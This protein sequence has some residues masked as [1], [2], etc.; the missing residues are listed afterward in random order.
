MSVIGAA[1]AADIMETVGFVETKAGPGDKE[2]AYTITRSRLIRILGLLAFFLVSV[3]AYLVYHGI[4]VSNQLQMMRS[5]IYLQRANKQTV[6]DKLKATEALV[7]FLLAEDAAQMSGNKDVAPYML[8]A[9]L[10]ANSTA[11]GDDLK[12]QLEKRHEE[13]KKELSQEVDRLLA[14]M[15][16]GSGRFSLKLSDEQIQKLKE[17][18]MESKSKP[19]LPPFAM[20]G[21]LR[22]GS[23][24]T[25]GT[26]GPA[27]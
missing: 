17:G 10:V 19:A 2:P 24:G 9:H 5:K 12:V 26:K 14:N 21:N 27:K 4:S 25:A 20:L 3:S 6:L 11:T 16:K 23:R 18:L 8:L 13:I 15:T 22:A 7:Q 1:A